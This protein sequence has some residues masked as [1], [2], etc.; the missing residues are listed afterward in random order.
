MDNAIAQ[1]MS[2]AY[3]DSDARK[4]L[5]VPDQKA[6]VLR[7][8]GK[9]EMAYAFK[10]ALGMINIVMEMGVVSVVKV[11]RTRTALPDRHALEVCVKHLP[12]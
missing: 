2:I 1:P 9:E 8:G 7:C 10:D 5:A 12:L 4:G 6:P 11:S 3:L